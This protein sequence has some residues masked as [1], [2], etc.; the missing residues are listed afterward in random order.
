MNNVVKKH[1][2]A[3][4]DGNILLNKMVCNKNQKQLRF[5]KK[6]KLSSTFPI[7]GMYGFLFGKTSSSPVYV[8]NMLWIQSNPTQ[9]EALT[10]AT[11]M[12][13]EQIVT[14]ASNLLFW[15]SKRLTHYP[16]CGI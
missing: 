15:L 11:V 14:E 7:L 2:F 3:N 10:Q 8:D 6:K 16:G 13:V 1:W 9:K 12:A 4:I 5:N